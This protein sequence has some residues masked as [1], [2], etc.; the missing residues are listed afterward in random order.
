MKLC[1]FVGMN[2]GGWVG[3]SLAENLGLMSAFL[4]SGIGSIIGVY[5]GW[6]IARRLLN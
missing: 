6:L 2:V 1:I 3:W 5:L 4:V